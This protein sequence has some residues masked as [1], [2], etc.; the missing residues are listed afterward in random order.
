MY[1]NKIGMH[2]HRKLKG[3]KTMVRPFIFFLEKTTFHDFTRHLL[4]IQG[5][6][7]IKKASHNSTI[8]KI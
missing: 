4:T 7:I 1:K 6:S 3:H 2:I 5:T 8:Q